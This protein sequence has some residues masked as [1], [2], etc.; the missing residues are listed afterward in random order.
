MSCELIAL[1]H[2]KICFRRKKKRNSDGENTA[3]EKKDDADTLSVASSGFSST[4]DAENG[5]ITSR[6]LYQNVPAGATPGGPVRSYTN[7]SVGD[8]QNRESREYVNTAS[9][10]QSIKK[11]PDEKRE[12]NKNPAPDDNT[13]S[14]NNDQK[15]AIYENHAAVDEEKNNNTEEPVYQNSFSHP[16]ERYEDYEN[17]EGIMPQRP[18]SEV[19]QN[20]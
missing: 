10:G 16:G 15:Y 13:D 12:E 5:G 11:K 19:Y 14:T 7:T 2:F 20:V 1:Q 18:E 6:E 17:V 9:W 3:A 4:G 8:K